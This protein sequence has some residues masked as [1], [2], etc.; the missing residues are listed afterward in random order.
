MKR[1]GDMKAITGQDRVR[2]IRFVEVYLTSDEIE[3]IRQGALV[4]KERYQG[5]VSGPRS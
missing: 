2:A 4:T 3:E 5:R 1:I